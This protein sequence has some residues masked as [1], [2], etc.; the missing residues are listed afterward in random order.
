MP[1]SIN[2]YMTNEEKPKKIVGTPEVDMK[3]SKKLTNQKGD[4]IF[5][6]QKKHGIA[7]GFMHKMDFTNLHPLDDKFCEITIKIDRV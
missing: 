5:F 1:A 6:I 7:R 2:V 3:L 4:V